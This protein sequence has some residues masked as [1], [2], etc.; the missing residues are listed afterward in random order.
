VGL[1]EKVAEPLNAAR[2]EEF[3]E[4]K[5]FHVAEFIGIK[6]R[7]RPLASHLSTGMVKT[8]LTSA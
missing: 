4:A 6:L 2:K 5:L 8:G 1:T 7:A 3:T